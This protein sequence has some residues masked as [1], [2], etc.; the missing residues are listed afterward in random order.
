MVVDF[1]CFASGLGPQSTSPLHGASRCLRV[2]VSPGIA[3]S[4]T[5]V[6]SD[7]RLQAGG[8]CMSTVLYGRFTTAAEIHPAVQPAADGD[9]TAAQKAAA[10][11]QRIAALVPSEVLVVYGAVLASA[12]NKADDG[13]TT[14]T[15]PDLLKW[16]IPVLAIVSLILYAIA[17]TGSWGRKDA[18]RIIIPPLAFIAWT[19]LTTTSGLPLFKAFSWISEGVE[20]L[21]G[22]VIAIL[23]LSLAVRL[24][25]TRP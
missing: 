4:D 21:V 25:P 19:L 11:G 2:R 13:S 23:L 8:C 22:G 5:Q 12:V 20:F 10:L 15:N 3:L 9:E 7:T 17:R 16:S 6:Q 24:T 14:V 18:G 1:A